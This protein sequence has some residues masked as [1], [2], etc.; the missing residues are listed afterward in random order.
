MKGDSEYLT[1]LRQ[2]LLRVGR[3][4]QMVGVF[5]LRDPEPGTAGSVRELQGHEITPNGGVDFGA[6]A[7]IWLYGQRLT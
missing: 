2:V 4:Y 7:T 1:C 5:V 6:M 3:V